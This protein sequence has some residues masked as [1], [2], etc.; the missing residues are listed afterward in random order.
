MGLFSTT[1]KHDKTLLVLDIGSA[2][3][4][5]A[6]VTLAK[7][8]QGK[9]TILHSLRRN[10]TVQKEV[11]FPTLLKSMEEALTVVVHTLLTKGG[12]TPQEI[13]VFLSSPWN[14]SQTR[15]IRVK[16]NTPFTVSEKF[17]KDIMNKE[18]ALFEQ[19][20]LASYGGDGDMPRMLETKTIALRLNGYTI[21][22]PLGKKA[23]EVELT[24]FLSMGV[25]S[26]LKRIEACIGKEYPHTKVSFSTFLFTSFV[27]V[28]DL[29]PDTDSFMLVDIGGEITDVSIIKKDAVLESISFPQGRNSL[30]RAIAKSDSLSTNESMSLLTLHQKDQLSPVESLKIEKA[31]HDAKTTWLSFFQK[32]LVQIATDLSLPERLYITCDQDVTAW[33]VRV[34]ESEDFG[35]YLLTEKK[36]STVVISGELLKQYI[37]TQEQNPDQFVMM[38]TLLLNRH[39]E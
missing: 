6:L 10:F 27:V 38:E 32:S 29:F 14:A 25:E 28:R 30:I 5:G 16:K 34:L 31:L 21:Q 35:Q 33:Y 1:K 13:C 37:L 3:V 20:E 9:P 7:D 18:I 24:L 11:S 22:N 23:K 17:M 2:S 15:V 8:T 19:A 12:T 4:C 26:V 39:H 36:F